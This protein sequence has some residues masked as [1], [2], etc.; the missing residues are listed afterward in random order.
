MK[1]C[2]LIF[3]FSFFLFFNTAYAGSI[4]ITEIMY[5]LPGSDSS[6]EW[7]EVH[8]KTGLNIDLTKYK[9]VE[10]GVAHSIV[11]F[12]GN[13]ELA[14]N[15]YA[16]IADNATNFLNDNPNFPKSNLYDSSFSLSNDKGESLAIKDPDGNIVYEIT[17]TPSLGANGDGKTLQQNSSGSWFA[18]DLNL[19]TNSTQNN[20]NNNT[21]S[22]LNNNLP[23]EVSPSGLGFI[24]YKKEP[25]M[26]FD[27]MYNQ[28]NIVGQPA[29]FRVQIFG[30]SGENITQG[31]F[32]WNFGDGETLVVNT[33]Q[34]VDHIYAFP[35]DYTV[36]LSYKYASW[37]PKPIA[38]GKTTINIINSPLI[39]KDLSLNPFPAISISNTKDSEYDISNYIIQTDSQNIKIP[40]GTYI[41][42]KDE[43]FIK[44]PMGSYS[45]DNIKILSP[46]GYTTASFVNKTNINS[47][48]KS[49]SSVY[50]SSPSISSDLN[51]Q[52][53]SFIP[54]NETILN[55][56]E[57]PS[58]NKNQNIY[59][60]IGFSIVILISVFSVLFI[61]LNNKNLEIESDEYLLQD[62]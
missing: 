1:S 43:I 22:T 18:G 24:P 62:E 3:I 54:N 35:G 61:R 46:S 19:T 40:E 15:E 30:F 33:N 2:H 47:N 29:V 36:S 42:A 39:L 45:K 7:V 51:N 52:L 25:S 16:I 12:D 38:I 10:S 49:I 50:K 48:S 21:D 58:T 6:R 31:V 14:N 34:E 17:Y 37:Y 13:S 27:F 5:D 9:L 11:H 41:G 60:Y 59:K 4:N 32:T 8:N 53:D 28:T 26:R 57:K 56:D 44:L 55:L 23:Q 20:I